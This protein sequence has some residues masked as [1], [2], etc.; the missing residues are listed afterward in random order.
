V[1]LDET[2]AVDGVRKLG[3]GFWP[4]YA[5]DGRLRWVMGN[6]STIVVAMP[7]DLESTLMLIN[8]IHDDVW[9]PDGGRF[10]AVVDGQLV[11]LDHDG[12]GVAVITPADASAPAW[13][14]VAE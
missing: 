7:D 8:D 12:E 3:S 14:R 6:Y 4:D 9:S 10:A 2:G 11:T 1:D 13:Q 5:P